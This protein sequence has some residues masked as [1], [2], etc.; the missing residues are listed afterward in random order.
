VGV[1]T[2]KDWKWF[3]CTCGYANVI[4]SSGDVV[5]G[6]VYTLTPA[7]EESLDG[8]EGTPKSYVKQI[9]EVEM[10]GKM[11]KTLVYVDVVR[12]HEGR[13]KEEYIVRMGSAISDALV[14]GVPEWYIDKYLR[15]S[16]GP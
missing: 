10:A 5:Y 14:K 4:Q 3:I 9:H 13:I 15:P 7:D 2:L 1:A 8:Y 6:M 16:V 11:V 12:V